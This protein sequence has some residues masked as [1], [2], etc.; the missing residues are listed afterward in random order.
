MLPTIVLASASPARKMLLENAGIK[1]I[2]QVS[3][4]DEDAIAAT[5]NWHK[6][7]EIALGLACKS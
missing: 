1:P 6:P 3:H 4:L 7:E 2:I 5:N